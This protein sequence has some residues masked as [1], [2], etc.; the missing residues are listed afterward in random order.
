MPSLLQRVIALN[1]IHIHYNANAM[2]EIEVGNYKVSSS[3]KTCPGA[4]TVHA[5]T[6]ASTK[7]RGFFYIRV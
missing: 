7:I 4:R 6:L 3:S 1:Y 2:K 5:F